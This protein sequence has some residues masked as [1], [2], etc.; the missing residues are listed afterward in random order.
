MQENESAFYMPES[1]M[2]TLLQNTISLRETEFS[3]RY[4][5]YMATLLKDVKETARLHPEANLLLQGWWIKLR[6]IN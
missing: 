3:A 2:T 1:S 4:G 6:C 5:D